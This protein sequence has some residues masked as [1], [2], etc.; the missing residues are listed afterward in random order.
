[1]K[2]VFATTVL[3]LLALF[4]NTALAAARAW[5]EQ[6]QVALG[7][8]VTLN[9]ET[10]EVSAVPDLTPLMADFALEGQSNSRSVRLING[11]MT[12]RTVYAVILAPK[13]AGELRIPSLRVGGQQTAPLTLSVGAN[14]TTT[15]PSAN[16]NAMAFLETEIDDANPY[17]QQSVGVTVR[18]YYAVP[19]VSGQLDLDPPEGALLQRVGEIT[20]STREINGRRYST[21][22]RRFL[23]VPERSGP[24]TIPGPRFEG[25]GAGSWMDD[26]LGGNSREMRIN[27]APRT[28]QV[29]AQPAAVPQPWLPLR[30]L[31]MRYVAAPQSLHAGEAATLAIEVTA[32]GAT[33]AQMP[34]M[35]APSVPGAQVFAEPPQYDET[36]V[37]GTPQVKLT[38]RYSVVPSKTGALVIPGISMAWWDVRAG[39]AKTASLPDLDLQVGASAGGIPAP[40]AAVPD[41][42]VAASEDGA[43][44]AEG[45]QRNIPSQ[46]WPWLAAGFGLLWLITLIWALRKRG[47]LPRLR[48]A[49]SSTGETTPA[50]ASTR[51]LSDLKR[52]LDT[53][54]LAEAGE[55]LCAMASPPAKDLD[56][57][58]A[59]LENPKQRDAVEQ[60]RRACWAGG[61]IPAARA[62]VWQAFRQGPAWKATAKP[63][64]EP[65]PPLYPRT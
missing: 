8:S 17:V 47:P 60:L 2:R 38:R 19:L 46:V 21:A 59:R 42:S 35:P 6:P 49:P 5:L 64:Q 52:V 26:L 56:A 50:S 25:R 22:E 7:E 44:T 53:G 57:L 20:Q 30:D 13:R 14:A 62:A 31:R 45:A 58:I 54:D 43:F 4:S 28:L 41:T 48:T 32:L 36:F 65:L 29:R 16:S 37:A 55:V 33:Q 1:M 15:T 63:S 12:S 18:L 11:R 3:L 61:D 10:D 27:G 40:A 24:L 39:T 51:T 9:V 34:E 23:L